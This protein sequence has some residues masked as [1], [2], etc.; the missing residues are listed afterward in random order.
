[1]ITSEPEASATDNEP[2]NDAQTSSTAFAGMLGKE[3]AMHTA[4]TKRLKDGIK[5]TLLSTAAYGR[6]RWSAGPFVT[7]G[8]G[9]IISNTFSRKGVDKNGNPVIL[10]KYGTGATQKQIQD[11]VKHAKRTMAE[12]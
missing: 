9:K 8:A 11:F 4:T 2:S 7:Q 10:R 12:R 1:M 5:K 6:V 3:A